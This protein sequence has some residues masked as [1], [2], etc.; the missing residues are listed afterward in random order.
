MQR[1][2][3]PAGVAF[4]AIVLEK[5]QPVSITSIPALE[6]GKEQNVDIQGGAGGP[7]VLGWLQVPEADRAAMS[8]AQSITAPVVHFTVA[9]SARD[10]DPLPPLALLNGAFVL[11]RGVPVGE[12]T[13]DVA[14][15]GW[16]AH[17]VRTKVD[18][19]NVTM[20][21]APLIAR[22]ASSIFISW[23][24]GS[25]LAALDRSLG[26]CGGGDPAPRLMIS[27]AACASQDDE[28]CRVLRQETFDEQMPFGT[29][30]VDDVPPGT[31]RA[32]LH[33][34]KLPPIREDVEVAALQQKRVDLYAQY[35]SIYGGFSLGGALPEEDVTLKFPE[36]GVGFVSHETGEYRAVLVSMFSTDTRI[37]AAACRGGF[38]AFALVSQQSRPNTRF[39]VEIPDNVLEVGVTDTFTRTPLDGATV[40]Y[41][42]M[43]LPQPR[44]PVVTGD[45]KTHAE[46]GQSGVAA[47][48][49][50]PERE[51]QLVVSR[52]GYQKQYMR[53]F[54]MPRSE[55]KRIDVE[56]VPLRGSSG[57]IISTLPFDRGAVYWFS[58]VGA[59]TERADL[60]ADGAFIYSGV[61]GPEETLAVVS[62]SHPLWVTRAPSMQRHES[63]EV[64]FPPMAAR[65]F[66]TVIPGTAQETSTYI[67][68]Y[69]GG[70]RVPQAALEAHQSLRDLPARVR[71]SS[72]LE[73][74][75]IGE[76]GPIEVVLGPTSAEVPP[77]AGIPDPL[78]LPPYAGGPR[79]RL[80]PGESRVTLERK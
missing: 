14:G 58:A 69:V 74:R 77:R 76:T 9:G 46:G 44:H 25:D 2:T 15:R 3:V 59:I 65:A 47:M 51:I 75:D 40:N 22:V 4:W 55:T 19:R 20:V 13:L 57:R 52:A 8:K 80:M 34:G 18:T 6:A 36:G 45:L 24:K 5:S 62:L 35:Y 27:V 41:S 56:L 37:D 73:L 66:Q 39:D 42:I 1:V 43:S 63:F 21:T 54:T 53:S 70:L 30:T 12:G 11:V 79:K 71:G 64:P 67:G 49:Y 50:V 31:Y 26:S 60:E 17:R 28:S 16:I 33:F 48:K 78:A 68:L 38:R 29:L 23:S 10:S 32:E 72:A 61:H 7:F